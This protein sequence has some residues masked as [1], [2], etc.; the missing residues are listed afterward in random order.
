M[1]ERLRRTTPL[2]HAGA[3]LEVPIRSACGDQPP[4]RGP[5]S[6]VVSN[7]LQQ[8]RL[9]LTPNHPGRTYPRDTLGLA[10][11]VAC[12]V[13]MAPAHEVG[14]NLACFKSWRPWSDL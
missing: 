12:S 4:T 11:R 8:R 13:S 2:T 6:A 3:T 5:A 9:F 7:W 1:K 10:I 14:I